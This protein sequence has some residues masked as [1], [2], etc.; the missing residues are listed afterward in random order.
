MTNSIVKL[1][2]HFNTLFRRLRSFDPIFKKIEISLLLTFSFLFAIMLPIVDW[3]RFWFLNYFVSK[4]SC[5]RKYLRSDKNLVYRSNMFL[6]W[7][8]L[9]VHRLGDKTSKKCKE[10]SVRTWVKKNREMFYEICILQSS[11]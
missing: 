8:K 4:S 10:L 5:G 7:R 9:K 6:F 1:L 2:K 11:S 3:G